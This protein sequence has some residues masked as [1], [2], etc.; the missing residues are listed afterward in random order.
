M[1][2]WECTLSCQNNQLCFLVTFI[3]HIK[4][5][6]GY[7]LCLK[8]L[9]VPILGTQFIVNKFLPITQMLRFPTLLLPGYLSLLPCLHTPTLVLVSTYGKISSRV[10]PRAID[11]FPSHFILFAQILLENKVRSY[12]STNMDIN[13]MIFQE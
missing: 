6:Q 7:H 8:L 2:S 9:K 5:S 3:D 11:L 1:R 10:L 13:V 4:L 12:M